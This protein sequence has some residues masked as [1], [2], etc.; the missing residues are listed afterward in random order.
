MNHPP[1]RCGSRAPRATPATSLSARAEP[2]H[3]VATDGAPGWLASAFAVT[4][5]CARLPVVGRWLEPLGSLVA[6]SAWA[7]RSVF[8]REP[9]AQKE[10]AAHLQPR[11]SVV[12][13]KPLVVGALAGAVSKDVVDAQW[14]RPDRRHPALSGLLARRELLYR[15]G[16]R[17]G[18]SPRQVLDV[19]RRHDQ[20][21]RPAP[22]LLFLPGGAWLHSGRVMQG[23]ALLAEMAR[24]G[25]LCL[26]AEYRVAPR[27]RWP[28]HVEDALAAVSWAR[29][30]AAEYGGDAGF[31]AVAGASAGGH[32]AALA[33]L[34]PDD[35]AFLSRVPTH[36]DSAVNAVIGL[37]GRYDWADRATRERHDFVAFVQN[38]V[39]RGR[40]GVDVDAVCRDASPIVRAHPGSPPFLVIH[41]T[42]DRVIPVGEARAFVARMREVSRSDVRYL[43]LPGAGHG[44]DLTDWRSTHAAVTASALFLEQ[45]RRANIRPP[46]PRVG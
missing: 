22:V 23:Y 6:A 24:R 39:V 17:Y 37:Y 5:A 41:G 29:T 4:D 27:Y 12:G 11:M 38:V 2:Q 44:F 16:I 40:N 43:E 28:C 25:W 10:P 1:S 13:L 18:S 20:W 14:G 45:A 31:V 35:P 15:S 8:A 3:A 21:D 34:C 7:S 26:S 33:G 19:W 42:H 9:A 32:L 36:A 46:L 30:H